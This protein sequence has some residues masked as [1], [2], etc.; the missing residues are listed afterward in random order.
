MTTTDP[1]TVPGFLRLLLAPESEHPLLSGFG[2]ALCA[3]IQKTDGN[4]Y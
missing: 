1:A 2:S 3:R 4:D